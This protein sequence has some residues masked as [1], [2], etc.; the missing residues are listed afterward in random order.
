MLQDL[1]GYYACLGVTPE[2]S[3]NE[4]KAA[5]RKLAKEHHPDSGNVVDG[6]T[7]FKLITESYTV[8]ADAESRAAYDALSATRGATTQETSGAKTDP[9]KCSNCKQT[10]AQPKYVVYRHLFSFVLGTVRTPVQGIYCAACARKI[11]LKATAISAVV[12]WWGVPWG[13]IWTV[14]ECLKNALGGTTV[15]AANDQLLWHN[16]VAFELRGDHRLSLGLADKLRGSQD[17]EVSARAAKLIEHFRSQGVELGTSV[18]KDPWSRSPQ[19]VLLHALLLGAVPGALLIATYAGTYQFGS[20]TISSSEA[21]YV[22]PPH[23][24]APSLLSADAP[25]SAAPTTAAIV[26]TCKHLPVNGQILR[27]KRL[28]RR[29]G[30][31]LDISNGSSGNAIIKLRFADTNRLLA[32]FFVQNNQTASLAGI[33]DGTYVLQYAF[34]SLLKEDCK[35]FTKVNYAGQFPQSETL[36]T[37]RTETEL[38]TY[39]QSMHVSYTLYSVPGGNVRPNTISPDSFDA[40]DP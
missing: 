15:S 26:V 8:L 13:P 33:P 25:I 32:S 27:G 30:H 10:A 36:A 11:A 24:S 16:A 21:T 29:N 7:H 9:I 31:L 37:G 23:S 40:N 35:S 17:R 4:I 5:Y 39:L 28:L 12:G 3:Q 2:A 1:K 22:T 19:H 6:A 20:S 18:L 34:G 14:T 38:G